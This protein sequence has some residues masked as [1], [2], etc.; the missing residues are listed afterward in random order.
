[1]EW[2]AI[3]Q[4]PKHSSTMKNLLTMD[5]REPLALFLCL[6]LTF[7]PPTA[8]PQHAFLPSLKPFFGSNL[9]F[10]DSI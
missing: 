9:T 1:M 8:I 10:L 5:Q 6:L 3:G 2:G 4:N 7:S